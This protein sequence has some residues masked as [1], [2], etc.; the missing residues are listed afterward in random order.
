MQPSSSGPPQVYS[1][2]VVT[3]NAR[4]P[5][6]VGQPYSHP[7]SEPQHYAP[8][9]PPP[10]PR[11]TPLEGDDR[12]LSCRQQTRQLCHVEKG[13]KLCLECVSH[14]SATDC[15]FRRTV[16]R[17][18]PL[19]NFAW[20]ELVRV[21]SFPPTRQY[22]T[23]PPPRTSIFSSQA[24]E[25]RPYL[26]ERQPSPPH[27]PPVPAEPAPSPRYEDPA[28]RAF[29]PPERAS[30]PRKRLRTTNEADD[31]MQIDSNTTS[32]ASDRGYVDI[33]PARAEFPAPEHTL[34]PRQEPMARYVCEECGREFRTSSEYKYV[35]PIS[36]YH[37]FANYCSRKHMQRHRPQWTCT[38]PGC[39]RQ[40]GFTTKNDLDRHK[41]AVHKVLGPSDPYWKCF[42]P[43]CAKVD[44]VWPRL[45]NFKAHVVRMHG[46]EYVDDLLKKYVVTFVP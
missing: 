36:T 18:G 44:K 4:L 31:S 24:H 1:S 25:R 30:S 28:P 17:Q 20:Q 22:Y 26:P 29:F 11:P 14:G 27:R 41:K 2:N 13:A 40:E 8:P 38:F 16:V 19:D 10:P 3:P 6:Q 42:Y 35:H 32:D 21:D 33:R 46:G 9:P 5:L 23:L 39:T 15:L 34:A 12:C 37:S 7:H 45:D 43:G